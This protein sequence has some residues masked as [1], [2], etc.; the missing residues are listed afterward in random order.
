MMV[1]KT[2]KLSFFKYNIFVFLLFFEEI[3]L[4]NLESE[5]LSGLLYGGGFDLKISD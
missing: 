5:L 1:Q 4:Y 2:E 3:L